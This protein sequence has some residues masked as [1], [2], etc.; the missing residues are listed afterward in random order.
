MQFPFAQSSVNNF[1]PNSQAE[2]G[3]AFHHLT[4][5]QA[6]KHHVTCHHSV[7]YFYLPLSTGATLSIVV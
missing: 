6:Y 4:Q 5:V 7:I 3:K 1:T 2:E